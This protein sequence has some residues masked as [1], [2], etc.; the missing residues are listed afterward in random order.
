MGVDKQPNETTTRCVGSPINSI[1]K[2]FD[3]TMYVRSLRVVFDGW[4]AVG[5][6]YVGKVS[7][8][9]LACTLLV[10]E[11]KRR[12][13]SMVDDTAGANRADVSTQSTVSPMG[14]LRRV[15]HKF[16]RK[17]N[18]PILVEQQPLDA[19]ATLKL[20]T[21]STDVSDEELWGA[22]VLMRDL[23]KIK[24][25]NKHKL[26]IHKEISINQTTGASPS[27]PRV[28]LYAHI[29]AHTAICVETLLS[30]LDTQMHSTC[31]IMLTCNNNPLMT[32]RLNDEGDGHA[33]AS[34][35]D[36]FT[37]VVAVQPLSLSKHRS[38]NHTQY[39]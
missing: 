6:V 5:D 34:E 30:A 27:S 38:F 19:I 8:T 29:P 37:L 22:Y 31:D 13:D 32:T 7:D 12:V 10:K 11:R 20:E 24:D 35:S 26:T 28:V 3:R 21:D 4:K 36:K 23:D 14:P 17:P 16:R 1:I 25:S 15:L 33:G 18:F 9:E 2:T 39:Q